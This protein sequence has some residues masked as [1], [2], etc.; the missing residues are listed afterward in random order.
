[1]AHHDML[2]IYDDDL[3]FD[4][5]RQLLANENVQLIRA[6]HATP[7]QR[8]HALGLLCSFRPLSAADLAIFPALQIISL[9]ASESPHIDHATLVARGIT[10]LAVGDAST[11]EVAAHTMA[12]ILSSMRRLPVLS[13]RVRAGD[14]R[15]TDLNLA[16]P[17]TCTLGVIGYGQIGE[18]VAQMGQSVFGR[19]LV[20]DKR[21]SRDVAQVTIE[22]LLRESHVLSL[23]VPAL[24]D[25]VPLLDNDMFAFL[26]DGA[27]LVNTARAQL[28]DEDSLLRALE[29]G[30][31]SFAALDVILGLGHSSSRALIAH[32][33]CTVTPHCA[34]FSRDAAT[35]YVTRQVANFMMALRERSLA[36][37]HQSALLERADA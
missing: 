10:L 29:S 31:V 30:K 8:E 37:G 11:D 34:Y 23:H 16:R 9:S 22:H 33:N 15:Y 24:P 4:H 35:E 21:K 20:H 18:R 14:W 19:V 17:S 7:A 32:P 12:L 27:V 6:S 36:P 28:I 2:A 5:A 3:D 13:S 26:K 1:M 25:G